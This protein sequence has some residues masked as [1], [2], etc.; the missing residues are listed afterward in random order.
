MTTACH[1]CIWLTLM[2]KFPVFAGVVTVVALADDA[3]EKAYAPPLKPIPVPGVEP[4]LV[5]IIVDGAEDAS[6][7][8]V[9]A[10]AVVFFVNIQ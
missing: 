2:L 6:K 5:I 4:A 3:V 9:L 1:I 8:Y 10:P 7:V